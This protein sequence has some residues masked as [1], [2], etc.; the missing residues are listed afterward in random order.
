MSRTFVFTGPTLDTD[1][2]REIVPEAEMRPPV[3]AGDL[4]RLAPERGDVVALIDGFYFQAAAVRHKEILALLHNGVHVWGA[5]SMGALRAAELFPFGMR[6]FG[7]IFA[8]YRDGVIDGDDEVAILHASEELDHMKLTEALVN[9]RYAC[10]EAVSGG[11]LSREDAQLITKTAQRL[12]FFE[13]SYQRIWQEVRQEGL[14]QPLIEQLQSFVA[15]KHLDLKRKDAIEMVQALQSP[16]REPFK[17]S[18]HLHETNQLHA[19]QFNE[20][21]IIIN[22]QLVP[23]KDV[24]TAY[25]LFSED[26]QQTHHQVLRAQLARFAATLLD[27]AQE[28]PMIDDAN[29][30]ERDSIESIARFFFSQY[31]FPRTGELPVSARRWLRPQELQLTRIEQLALLAMRCW[32]STRG[33]DRQEEMI[34]FIKT[35]D[36]FLP[37]A[38]IAYQAQRFS[39]ALQEKHY[40]V[41]L[42]RLRPDKVQLWAI[43]RWQ[44][45]AAD[46]EMTLLDRGF[47]SS[48]DFWL[49]A[50][51][52]YLLDK[53]V[54]VTSGQNNTAKVAF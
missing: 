22:N 29:G 23:D 33:L 1:T 40:E 50:R 19:W 47:R 49:A 37:L 4:L 34:R 46:F 5:A 15:Q 52:Y 41:H 12:P 26:Y 18:F 7:Q 21:G 8:A 54:G 36:F 3:A 42:E 11:L 48:T 51:P 6:G 20:R 35:R 9:I 38:K 2:V 44:V 25:Q 17:P 13:R 45:S 27:S 24:L 53:Y 16:P 31:H 39:R 43:E 28:P 30:K 10:Q 32:Q 14:P